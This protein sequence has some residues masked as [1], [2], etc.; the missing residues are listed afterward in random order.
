[1]AGGNS[2]KDPFL[3][4][5]RG[6]FRAQIPKLPK[7]RPMYIG[8]ALVYNTSM[9]KLNFSIHEYYHLYSRG[10]D[11]RIIFSDEEDK[12]R[13]LH[14]LYLCNTDSS[15]IFREIPIGRAYEERKGDTL[16]NIGAYCMMP[17]HFHLLVREKKDG[18]ITKFMGKLLTSYS[19][20]FNKKYK[21]TG[22]LF[23]SRFK[24]KHANDDKYLK[25]L[26]AYIHLNPVKIIDPKWKENGIKDRDSAE[27]YLESY[28]YS[29]Y[30]D[31]VG[32]HRK[33]SNILNKRVFP[34]YFSKQQEFKEFIKEW[35][36]YGNIV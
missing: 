27:E 14:L 19:M 21:R 22:T 9:R 16:V 29:S 28:Q 4:R 24:A 3:L 17:N 6:L 1:M 12:Q 8:R 33:E 35:L 2:E 36:S 18:G 26:F 32:D 34:E 15:L 25:Y 5:E 30:A 23:E 7:A 31:Y 11:K 20:Y 10:T 13:F